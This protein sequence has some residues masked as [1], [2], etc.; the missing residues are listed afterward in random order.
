LAFLVGLSGFLAVGSDVAQAQQLDAGKPPGQIFSSTCAVCHRS[1]RGLLKSVSPGALPGFLRQHYTTG[2]DMAGVMAAYVLG[3]GGTDRVA[4]PPA[5]REPKQRAKGDVPDVGTRT[6]EGRE[7]AKEQSKSAKQRA[8]AKKSKSDPAAE[9]AKQ[10]AAKGQADKDKEEIAKPDA[11]K[12]DAT[13]PEP[14]KVEAAKPALPA[15]PATDA[16]KPEATSAEPA[17]DAPSAVAA[18]A[19]PP[20]APRQPT[21]LLTLPGFPPPVAEP[22]SAATP[23]SGEATTAAPAQ[24]PAASETPSTPTAAETPKAESA[25]PAEAGDGTKLDI[26]QEEVHAPAPA[27]SGQKKRVPHPAQ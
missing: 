5:K 14:E 22:E 8:A 6:P 24:S 23:A 17:R 4:E 18:P 27:R 9:A 2:A 11:S 10:D 1:P 26:M 13:K 3:N 7:Q 20:A 25:K 21:S 16:A 12:P 19:Q 15:T